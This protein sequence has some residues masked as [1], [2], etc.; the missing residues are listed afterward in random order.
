MEQAPT[1]LRTSA[2]RLFWQAAL[3]ACRSHLYVNYLLS[4]PPVTFGPLGRHFLNFLHMFTK[5]YSNFEKVNLW[6]IKFLIV[7]TSPKI[8]RTSLRHPQN[9]LNTFLTR[10]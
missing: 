5:F 4:S 2:S 3:E 7:E 1:S 9:S 6:K 10:P 8:L